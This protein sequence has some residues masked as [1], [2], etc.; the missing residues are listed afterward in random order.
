MTGIDTPT[1]W[2]NRTQESTLLEA[3][4]KGAPWS[5]DDL[6]FVVLNTATMRDEDLAYELGRTLYALWSV[7][8]RIKTGELSLESIR[9]RRIAEAP[10]ARPVCSDHF[11]ELL[12]NG[13]CPLD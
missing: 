7:Q 9:I 4:A 3:D 6:E 12:A 8:N 2:A 5:S 11:V 1:T 10:V 13:D